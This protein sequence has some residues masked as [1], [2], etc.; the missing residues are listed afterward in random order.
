MW[1]EVGMHETTGVKSQEQ[2]TKQSL[3]TVFKVEH[4]L[5]SKKKNYLMN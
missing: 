2:P 1:M 5:K 3:P 4:M